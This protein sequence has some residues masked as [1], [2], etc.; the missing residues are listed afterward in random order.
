MAIFTSQQGDRLQIVD[1]LTQEEDLSIYNIISMC[2]FLIILNSFFQMRAIKEELGDTDEDE[3]DIVA[4]DRK[5]Q[6]SGMPAN[7]WKHTQRELRYVF[8]L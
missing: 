5:L 6:S 8:I 3:D 1:H 2:N 4:L 7:V